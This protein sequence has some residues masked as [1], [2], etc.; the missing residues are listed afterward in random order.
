VLLSETP[1]DT[2]MSGLLSDA[3][4]AYA[5]LLGILQGMPASRRRLVVSNSWGMFSPGWDFPVGHPGN[6]SDNPAHPFNVIVA[7]LDAAGADILFAAGNCGRD[8]PDGRCEFGSGQSI[9][10]AN[11]H[12]SVL[13]VAGVDTRKRRVGYS[14]Q[15]PG[16]LDPRKPDLSAY[17][18]F[19]GSG[20]SGPDSGTSAACPVAAGV[21]AAVRSRHPTSAL[22]PAELRTLLAKTAEDLGGSGFDH[23]FGWGAVDG[24][25]LA[26]A[27]AARPRRRRTG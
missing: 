3:V 13:S 4:L 6:Y 9:G 1:G 7:S 8:C 23:D 2:V 21:V 24:T 26:A 12:P 5:R 17:T 18:H 14:S 10:G 27:L 25:A 20:V 19:T 11:S 15:G 16:R 22:S